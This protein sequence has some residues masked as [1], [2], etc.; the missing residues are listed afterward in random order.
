MTSK[1]ERPSLV[2]RAVNFGVAYRRWRAAGKPKR[3]KERIAEIMET[4]CAPCEFFKNGVCWHV[5]CGC[6]VDAEE[7]FRN[8]LA[9]GTEACPD[10]KWDAEQAVSA[11]TDA[12]IA[13]GIAPSEVS[14]V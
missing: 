12:Q 7:K 5:K 4:H 9:W 3:S 8:K 10:G 1:S 6:A 14:E 13:P 11:K 2:Q